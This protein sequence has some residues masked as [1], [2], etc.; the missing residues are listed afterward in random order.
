MKIKPDACF[1]CNLEFT[2]ENP[3]LVYWPCA[4][5]VH[6]KC[7]NVLE[8][9]TCEFCESDI[10]KIGK[11]KFISLSPPASNEP[12]IDN[13]PSPPPASPDDLSLDTFSNLATSIID[14][15][16]GFFNKTLQDAGSERISAAESVVN[17]VSTSI[18][19]VRNHNKETK[20]IFVWY[21]KKADQNLI[22]QVN[23][24]FINLGRN[25]S[26]SKQTE[27]IEND[28]IVHADETG[29]IVWKNR[30][31]I[32]NYPALRI[33]FDHPTVVLVFGGNPNT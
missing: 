7:L 16:T 9:K 3:P 12:L 15:F 10:D 22:D 13:S 23:E 17:L 27:I 14:K 19:C 11:I 21:R 4:C 1:S 2:P 8:P 6:K 30:V 26:L 28:G 24:A 32:T 18:Q 33:E 29:V 31:K 20:E 25:V 5:K